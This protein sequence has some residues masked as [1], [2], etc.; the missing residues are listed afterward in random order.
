MGGR[1]GVRSVA[2]SGREP[3]KNK[4]QTWLEWR[5]RSQG[6]QPAHSL[7][8]SPG[9]GRRGTP[10]ADRAG[11]VAGSPVAIQG[12]ALGLPEMLLAPALMLQLALGHQLQPRSRR[13]RTPIAPRM[14]P[15]S[16]R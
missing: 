10:L 4:K 3:K 11:A 16:P 13:R 5:Q 1:C 15:I 7:R 9:E 14:L 12:V 6:V 2:R 8:G